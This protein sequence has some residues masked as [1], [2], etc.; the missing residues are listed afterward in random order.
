MS[1]T[2][3]FIRESSLHNILEFVSKKSSVIFWKQACI[4]LLLSAEAGVFYFFLTK[5][6]EEILSTS[7]SYACSFMMLLG[8]KAMTTTMFTPFAFFLLLRRV[9]RY[10]RLLS[11]PVGKIATTSFNQRKWTTASLYSSL[12][13]ET[14]KFLLIGFFSKNDHSTV[15][16]GTC[17]WWQLQWAAKCAWKQTWSTIV[18]AMTLL[19][20]FNQ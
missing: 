10:I 6:L 16:H 18:K 3:L 14:K 9:D 15:N 1:V 17:Q 20:P 19:Q 5:Q 2:Q 7:I 13:K 8:D 4:S 11:K 12:C